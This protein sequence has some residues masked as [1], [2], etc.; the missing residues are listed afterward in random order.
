MEHIGSFLGLNQLD[1]KV[2][3]LKRKLQVLKSKE[4]DIKEELKQLEYSS[5][6]KKPRKEVHNWLA[7]VERIKNQVQQ[8]EREIQQRRSWCPNPQLGKSVD[9]LII[10][11]TELIE[12]SKFPRGLT[13]EASE[14]EGVALLTKRLI[15][16]KFEENKNM[17]WDC[18]MG[19]E[20]SIIGVYGMEGVGKTTLL[21]HI[22]N[23]LLDHQSF[24]VYWVTVSQN[25][26]IR[27]L[28]HDIAK[29]MR[30]EISET[31]DEMKRAA[32]LARALGRKKK[33]ILILDD[34]WD[35][36]SL[37]KV[38]IRVGNDGC[39]LVLTT[40]SLDVCRMIDC[41]KKIKV[42]PLSEAEA[43]TLFMETL[44]KQTLL[45]RQAEG[46]AKS[47]VEECDGLPL[48]IIVMAGSMRGV[49]EMHEWSNALEEI[50]EA[51]Y[52][53]DEMEFYGVFCVL[54]C[55][56][57][58]LK[59][60]KVKECLLYCS[61]FPEDELIERDDLIEYFIDEKLIDGMDSRESKVHKG[62]TI[63]NKLE[64]VCL[65]E[66]QI[67]G[68]EKR[69]VKMQDLVRDMAVKI[70]RVSPQFL[71]Q[72]GLGLRDLP[73]EEKWSD[74]LVRVSFMRNR[75]KHIPFDACPRCPQLSTLLLR[76]NHL[77]KII[78]DSFFVDMR[79][80]SI[81][82]LSDTSIES[83]PDSVSNLT[84]LAA[85]LLRW[86]RELGSVPSLEHLTALRRLDL[87]HT[88]IKEVPEGIEKL[89]NLRYL[90]LKGCWNLKMIPNG[91]LPQLAGTEF[92][93]SNDSV[94][95]K[96]GEVGS[97][98]K[99]ESFYGQFDNLDDLNTCVS[100]W[101]GREPAKY[102]ILVGFNEAYDKDIDVG[103]F[104]GKQAHL[105]RVGAGDTSVF[106]PTNIQFLTLKHCH[107]VTS[108]S[109]VAMLRKASDLRVCKIRYCYSI[110]HVICSCCSD[111][112]FPQTIEILVL[113]DVPMLTDLIERG[114]NPAS[115]S[116]VLPA[117]TFSS[118]KELEI[119]GCHELKMLFTP[120]LLTHF[121]S[122]ER[123]SVVNCRQLATI[124]GETLDNGH[125]DEEVITTTILTPP[126][127]RYLSLYYLRE[128]KTFCSYSM[129]ISDS[130]EEIRIIDCWKLMRITL[131]WD[132]PHPPPSLQKI[133]VP[134]KW[135]DEL[136]AWKHPETK[137]VLHPYVVYG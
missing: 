62:H 69:C 35:N 74:D 117:N 135:W 46:I 133:E 89:I 96:G 22:H 75:I 14:K 110:R 63:L 67:N 18:L 37:E 80:L 121:R 60:P 30:F 108:L 112:H 118:L 59:D 95:L 115:S 101:E 12:Q 70:A 88:R 13:L 26:S 85:L 50:K 65:L 6:R 45:S 8:Q 56:Y 4:D 29:A 77:L 24:K 57:D 43:W 104:F 116:I 90:S 55:S 94:A 5:R 39:K 16:E 137:D 78:S 128:L 20:D 111:L 54:K 42:E 27:K 122:L 61:L 28:Q 68:V 98:R 23:Q 15:G 91:I 40:R 72:A 9:R 106:L 105:F 7:E 136:L 66:G 127:L 11:A 99:L 102:T 34:V 103:A 19:G 1:E 114:S 119:N 51:K 36:I 124:I 21:T 84:S 79:M 38:G 52:R 25:F 125:K 126:K 83:L 2:D 107:G 130:L 132:E 48:A 32:E 44:G 81:L 131:L 92:F 64:N 113:Q 82:D 33:F 58:R 41:H 53:N 10:E 87:R 17:I 97:W 76:A 86:C 134:K 71:V 49:D 47:L 3:T 73:N 109:H 129:R 120:A 100:S 93:E 123:L 31:D